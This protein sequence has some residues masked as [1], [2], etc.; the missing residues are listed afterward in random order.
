MITIEVVPYT[1]NYTGIFTDGKCGMY[2]SVFGYQ[3]PVYTRWASNIEG[4]A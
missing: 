3:I 4:R 1:F 2:T